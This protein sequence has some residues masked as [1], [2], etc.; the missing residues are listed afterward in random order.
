[1]SVVKQGRTL[2]QQLVEAEGWHTNELAC[3]TTMKGLRDAE[4]A[5]KKAR[6]AMDDWFAKVERSCS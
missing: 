1:M 4:R 2:V 5:V 6:K 3:G